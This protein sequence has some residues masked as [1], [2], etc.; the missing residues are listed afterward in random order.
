MDERVRKHHPNPFNNANYFSKIFLNWI[1]PLLSLGKERPLKEE[2]L[3]SPISDEESKFLT[4]QL[5]REWNSELK[6]RKPSLFRAMFRIHI[7]NLIA[8]TFLLAV[9]DFTKMSFPLL[10]SQILRYFEGSISFFEA[11][12]FAT[13]IAIGV[14]VNCV[15]HH[16][17]FL[18][19]TRIGMKL[20]LASSGLLY[21][22]AFKLNMSGADNQLGGQLINMLSNDGTRVEYSVY[23]IPHLVIAPLQS[24]III[25]ILAYTIDISILS[26]LAI[27]ILAIPL[28]SFLGNAIDKL[29]RVT[30]KKCDKR[31][32]F[33]NEV[34]NGIK[35]IKMYCWEEPFRKIVEFLRGKEMK[36]Q[37]RLFMVATFNG[38]VDLILPSAITFTS[39]TFF[40]FFANRPLTPSYI[41]LAMSFYMRISNSLGFFFIK[42]ITTLIAAKVS[43]KR[44]EDFLLEK[45]IYKLNELYKVRDPYVKVNNLKARWPHEVRSLTLENISFEARQGDLIAVIGSVGAGKSSLLSSLLDE[46]KIISG[47]VDIKGSVFYVPQEPWI[48]TASLR[49][50]ILFGKDY[51]KKKF[52][53]IIKVCC[54][55]E[56]LKSLSNGE[57]TLIGE[58]GINLSGGQRAR[59]S[60]ARALY[61]DAQIYLFDDPLSAVDFN[62]A[63]KLYENC[64]NKYLKSKIRILVTHQ[65]HHLA[66]NVSEILYL[67]DGQIKFRGNFTDLIASG[68]NMDMIE[69][70]GNEDTKSCRSRNQSKTENFSDSYIND[71]A[72]AKLLN[73]SHFSDLNSSSL[74]LN[75]VVHQETNPL[76]EYNENKDFEEKR[77]YGVMS[78][79][80]YFNYFRAGG[81]LFGAIF[82]FLVYLISQSLIVGADYWVSYWASKEDQDMI[83]KLQVKKLNESFIHDDLFGKK[84][85]IKSIDIFEERV[86]YYNTYC[87]L[88]ACAVGIGIIRVSMFYTL[89]ARAAISMHSNMFNKVLKTPMRF[90]DT[91]PLGRIMNRFSKDIGYIDDLIPQT[92]GD[93]MIVLMMVL[94]S[95]SISL[96]INYWIIIPTIPLTFL[97][98]Y[99]RTYFL[100]TSMELKR[101]EGISRS[102]IFVHVNN[103]LSGMAI[104][105][106]ANMEEK[107]NEEFFVHTDYHTRA[108]SAFMYVNRWLGIRLDWVA[109]IFTYIALFSCILMKEWNFLAI[110]AGDVGLML[111]YLLQLVGLFQWTI[112]QS[113]EV[114]NLMTSVERVLEYSELETEPLDKGDRKPPTGWPSNGEITFDHVSFRY[115][116]NL[117]YVLN[118]M[119][120]K[121]NAGEKIGIVG[122]TGAG[123]SSIIQTLFRMAEPD[124]YLYID[125]INIKELSLHDLRSKLSIIPQEPTL[126]IGTI[127]TNLDPLNEYTDN[128]L[129]DAL[130]QVQLKETIKEMKDGL[131]S[132]V[133]KGGS[134]L[135]VGQKQL[136]CLAR[137]IIKKSKILIIDEAT[138]NVDFKTDAMVQEAIRECFKDCTV[139]TIA[140][141]LHTIIDNDRILC[142]S[143][144]R[145]VNFGRPYE[146][147]EDDTTILHDLVFSL[148][149]Q[150]RDK[151]VDMAKKSF[152][153]QRRVSMLLDQVVSN[154][155]N[156]EMENLPDDFTEKTRFWISPLLRKGYEKPL[157]ENDLYS[158]IDKEECKFLT[159]ELE[160]EWLNEL[161]NKNPSIIS[162]F[163]RIYRL[164]VF[165][166]TFFLIIQETN[167]ILF[168]LL[169]RKITQ[170]F[171]DHSCFNDA[172]FCAI[173]IAVGVTM[174]CF[175]HHWRKA[176]QK[177]DKRIEFLN[178]IFNGIKII[179]MYCWEKP[180]GQAARMF[181]RHE[182]KYQKLIYFVSGINSILELVLPSLITFTSV[183]CFVFFSNRPLTSSLIVLSMSFYLRISSAVGFYFFKAI[184]MTISGRVSLKRIETFLLAA[185]LNRSNIFI[186]NEN[187]KVKVCNLSARW[188]NGEKSFYLRD[189]N[190]EAKAGDLIGIMGSVGSGKS[191]FL[192]SLID[193]LE[194][195]SG[196]VDI[197]GSVFYVPQEPWIFTASLRQNILFGKDYDKKKF[198]EIIKVCCLEED[199]KSL[200]NGEHTLIGE[201]GINLS[202]GQRARVSV[203]RALY[204]DAQIYLFDDP[205]SAVDFNVAKKL[206]E[207][208]FNKYLKSKIRI[209][210][211]HQ[212]HHLASNVSEI[213][214]LV[215]G[216]IKFRGNFTDLIAS[217]VNMDM[218]EE[219]GKE[220]T[221][222]CRSR[223]NSKTDNVEIIENTEEDGINSL[224][225]R[226]SHFS[227][228]NMSVYS[229]KKV[230]DTEK[231]KDF[232]QLALIETNQENRIVGDFSFRTFFK[233]FR[234]GGGIFGTIIIFFIYFA[235]QTL[236]VSADYWVSH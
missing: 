97:F 125:D 95:V 40:I 108:N 155:S 182:M 10:I 209:L 117:S 6:K 146:L 233:Y 149:K 92:V 4:D 231:N 102:P 133:H 176:A 167:R 158:P 107:L 222:S 73:S 160:R 9:E 189:I 148:D 218:I 23:F 90:F 86:K 74:M 103:T 169:V 17:Y 170:Y 229:H 35:I 154:Q 224:F 8:M 34:F 1:S 185:N 21:K 156:S 83:T 174:N 177:C 59:V 150:E 236:I 234:K 20:R 213:L 220:D 138:A 54:L 124:G 114:E 118:D 153:N 205:L 33:I 194:K 183:S 66:S 165:F 210:V 109:S 57:H 211:T 113:C 76:P 173:F 52:D 166:L 27:I 204:S 15:V 217:G 161:K 225:L 79:K 181:R 142:L 36:Y 11:L 203:A 87:I 192:L 7:L 179:K 64:F 82:N 96:I 152:K 70:Q 88:I 130:A 200:S 19:L 67:V 202:G 164:R 60:V 226:S 100:A 24:A 78:W 26:G 47:D 137:A 178:E 29:R 135:S 101:I 157:T 215:D 195:V 93:F 188:S 50:N 132:E 3:Y 99:I 48:F 51:E 46:L 41:V 227:D 62:V 219:Q 214:Y 80:T 49:Q 143:Q 63:K 197:K 42:A 104:I 139:I 206:Y 121:I 91:N 172:V 116:K 122:R 184:I 208:C 129:W 207:N 71:S 32:N 18:E 126:F 55:E 89:S 134:N 127:R 14:T 198:D 5:E 112:R 30:A 199:L 175:L 28:Q 105:R 120:I 216:Q 72:D 201:K 12:K 221:K 53:E 159:D 163:V 44:M 84:E 31:I 191:S 180:F 193:E 145:V 85:E 235:S 144:G 43:I 77:I 68:V 168:P 98:I 228:L 147:I 65:V 25:F 190:M 162:C 37:K 39:V 212:V 140:H 69:E 56:D 106:A 171:N 131:E 111:V 61:S 223:I 230:S 119:N 128:V 38:I 22:K 123:K 13:Y 45:E 75:N 232:N 187:P 94:G 186:E 81:G 2:D 136:I 16:P 141:R 115:D 151:L 196:D 110:S 58:K